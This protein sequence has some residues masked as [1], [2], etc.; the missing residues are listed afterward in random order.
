MSDREHAI[1][2]EQCGHFLRLV[3]GVLALA[4]RDGAAEFLNDPNV[5]PLAQLF[6]EQRSGALR[7]VTGKRKKEAGPRRSGRKAVA[8]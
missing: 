4:E 7:T 2:T 8:R 5:A 1:M 6:R 3:A